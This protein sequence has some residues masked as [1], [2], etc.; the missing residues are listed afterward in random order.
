MTD[1]TISSWASSLGLLPVPVFRDDQHRSVLLNG[2]RGNF[3][4]ESIGATDVA[5]RRNT[6]W[7][8]NVGHY[9]SV[10]K[11]ALQVHRWSESPKSSEKYSLVSVLGDLEKFHRYLLS[12]EPPADLSVVPHVIRLYRQLRNRE[13]LRTGRESL[14]ALLVFL[15]S[16]TEEM[17][18]ERIELSKWD[19]PEQAVTAASSVPPNEWDALLRNLLDGSPERL[20]L[21]PALL[22][23]HAAGPVFQEAH[24][25]A[26]LIDANQM[27]LPGFEP[28]QAVVK[29]PVTGIGVHFTPP[30]LARTLVEQALSHS[31][32]NPEVT[33]VFDP[34]CGSGEF[35]RE[36]LR[37]LRQLGYGGKIILSGWD[38]SQAACD[39]ARFLLRREQLEDGLEVEYK[40]DCKDSLAQEEWPNDSD[41]LIMNPPFVSYENLAPEQLAQVRETLGKLARGRFELSTAFI[42]K[43][44]SCLRTAAVFA[45]IIPASFLESQSS[46]AVRE[47]IGRQ[48]D[49]RL[50]ARLGSQVLFPNA[51]I[52]AALYVGVKN[53]AQ[54]SNP[55]AFWADHRAT[56]TFDG[57][58][59]LRKQ[60]KSAQPEL[61][62]ERDGFSIYL[63]SGLGKGKSSWSP[64]P[65]TSWQFFRKVK[66]LPTVSD[67]FSVTT[68]VRSGLLPAFL[69]DKSFISEL[70]KAERT[71]FRPAVVNGSIVAGRLSDWKYVFYPYGSNRLK[72]ETELKRRLPH[73]FGGHF[74]KHRAALKSRVSGADKYWEMYRPTSWQIASTPK[75]VSVQYGDA[76]TF[77]WDNTGEFV[78]VGGYAWLPKRSSGRLS[79]N[80]FYAYLAILNSNI[81]SE[82]LSVSARRVR[83]GQFELAAKFV[84]PLPLPNLVDAPSSALVKALTSIGKRMHIGDEFDDKELNET[85]EQL[86]RAYA[87][88]QHA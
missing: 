54:H 7:S 39:M 27:L 32:R 35:L 17:P 49:P 77:A 24:R 26:A 14:L 78:V 38:I 58:R 63:A 59:E 40:I 18:R 80:I 68:G 82:L 4:L 16:A 22:L 31:T 45:A 70:P 43:A 42:W 61:L 10:E 85:V 65:Y 33:R 29:K 67:L 11:D 8:T 13:E 56:S 86:Y 72:S 46:A 57:L 66:D 83:G 79:E 73:F 5:A 74:L 44:V 48:V 20:R 6:A 37:Q 2:D 15:A 52:D 47:E 71:Y 76:G 34:A 50:L 69:V 23:R 30:A 81:F 21:Q 64:R 62:A 51:V 3:C 60:K 75:L 1:P 9:L 25:E 88:A 28:L 19:L 36:A 53:G 41:I 55:I 87:E 12:A 84:N